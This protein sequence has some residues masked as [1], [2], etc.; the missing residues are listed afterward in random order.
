MKEA[1]VSFDR[2]VDS[3]RTRGLLIRAK[4]CLFHLFS[5]SGHCSKTITFLV[6]NQ[7]PQQQKL[8]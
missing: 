4:S 7:G 3:I 2:L 8:S 1:A 6:S 5:V